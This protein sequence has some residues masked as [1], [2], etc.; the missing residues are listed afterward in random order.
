MKL[1]SAPARFKADGADSGNTGEFEAIVSVFNN[2]DSWGDVVRPG[3]FVDTIA[4]WKAS[5]SVLPVL[6]SH[7]MDDPTFNIGEV[8]DIA[9]LAAGAA[10]LPD[11][12]DPFVRD[13]GGLWVKG[14]I[15]TG[16]D[17]SPIAVQGL[18]LLKSRR[19]TQFSYAYDEVDA[20]W[21]T[22]DG[23]EAWELR[24]LELYEVSPTQIG[25]NQLT[26]LLVAKSGGPRGS[27]DDSGKA[28]GEE[29]CGVKPSSLSPES[30]RLLRDIARHSIALREVTDN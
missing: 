12:V 17:A 15:D 21:S 29:P 6:W 23:E 18:R 22:A 13:N 11:W 8:L 14:R 10:D 20:G 25:A 9:E 26:E 4:G 5:T 2:V 28:K 1:K 24:K 27:T 19:V 30:S 16:P 7:R 3:A